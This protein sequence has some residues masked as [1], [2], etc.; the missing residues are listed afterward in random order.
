MRGEG[1]GEG[2]GGGM[3]QDRTGCMVPRGQRIHLWLRTEFHWQ[4]SFYSQIESI[5]DLLIL[6]NLR[7]TDA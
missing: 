6:L 2:R 7:A 4:S 3:E 5:C 1:E